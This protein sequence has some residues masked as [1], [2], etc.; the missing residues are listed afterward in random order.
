MPTNPPPITL[1]ITINKP[2]AT[3]WK[4]WTTPADIMQWNIP[5]EDWHCPRAENDV[6]AGGTFLFRMEAKNGSAGFDHAGKYDKVIV[7]EL[8]EYTVNDGRR[9][10]ISFI[11][12]GN[13][14]ILRETFEPEKENPVEM[15]RDFCM[16]VLHH[17][18]QHAEKE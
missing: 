15:Q 14:T 2:A 17:F 13:T 7:N 12:Q 16:A 6:T 11:P 8:I 10:S 18:K 3:V 5:F 4:I 1:S 9:S